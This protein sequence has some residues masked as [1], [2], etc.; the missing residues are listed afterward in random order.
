MTHSAAAN[1]SRRR[2]ALAVLAVATVGIGLVVHR[3]MSGAVGDIAGDAL[4]AVLIYLLV[5]LVAPRWPR[6]A[7]AFLSF[8]VCAGVELL[9]LTGL[10]R[11]WGAMFPPIRL[12][13]GSGFDLRD[14]AVYAIAVAATSLIDMGVTRAV[15]RSASR[16]ATGRPPEGERPV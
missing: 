6:P 13:L 9:Q 5:A 12:V 10:P 16:N 8:V 15:G 1:T 7:V 4:Y 3:G 11:E 14:L 2:V